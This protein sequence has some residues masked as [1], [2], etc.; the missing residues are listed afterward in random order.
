[1][2][3][4]VVVAEDAA[5]IRAGLVR[6]LTG[7]SFEVVAEVAD[8][9]AL[10]HEARH[11]RPDLVVTDIRMPP[12][13]TDDG[14]RAA[15]QIRDELPET[16][17]LVLSQHIEPS[18]A[19]TLLDGRAGLGYLLKERVSDIDEF[20]AAAR[21][22]VGGA[23]V[24]DPIVGEQ[25]LRARRHDTAVESLSER[26][27]QVMAKIAEGRSNAAVAA[28]LHLSPKTVES[29]V[30]AIFRKLGIHDDP[31][32][33]RRVRAVVTWLESGRQ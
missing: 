31:D 27:R 13:G 10:L 25:L 26:E 2:P 15:A 4:T 23:S 29:H 6:V 17:V 11:L 9:D 1:V 16:A 3:I 5:L 22:V 7:A 18:A 20:V 28:E 21:A 12:T 8:A 33:H 24:I 19:I 14:L 32:E 30:S